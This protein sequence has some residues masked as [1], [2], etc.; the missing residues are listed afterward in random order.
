[1]VLTGATMT[2]VGRSAACS[3][4]TAGVHR[5]AK[6]SDREAAEFV[7]YS[8][9][10]ATALARALDRRITGEVRY[11]NGDR[12]LYATDASNYRQV[13]IGVVVPRSV[14]DVIETM[15]LCREHGA[16]FLSRGGGTSL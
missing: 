5:E 10:E 9:E 8:R 11:S 16:P 2:I 6:T 1:M 3:H 14:D 7:P 13:P 12:A 15:A 4:A